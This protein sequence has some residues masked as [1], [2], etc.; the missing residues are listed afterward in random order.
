M[1]ADLLA[2]W[3]LGPGVLVLSM[4]A[5]LAA[6]SSPLPTPPTPRPNADVSGRWVSLD[7]NGPTTYGWQ[8]VQHGTQ[9]EGTSL[10]DPAAEV[11]YTSVLSGS[12]T[13]TE[14]TLNGTTTQYLPQ[15]QENSTFGATLTVNADAMSGTIRFL[16]HIGKMDS[17]PMT[18]VRVVRGQ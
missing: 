1:R 14:F 11:P 10:D 13:G 3:R 8:L 5:A 17:R 16:P 7:A 12:V 18:F 9:V 15:G 2:G 4:L 6:C